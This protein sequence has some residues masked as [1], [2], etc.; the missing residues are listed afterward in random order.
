MNKG[1]K[2]PDHPK[3]SQQYLWP[4]SCTA[5][6]LDRALMEEWT[7]QKQHPSKVSLMNDSLTFHE[8]YYKQ[9]YKSDQ[10]TDLEEW[11]KAVFPNKQGEK[12]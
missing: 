4:N 11:K 6:S 9:K 7:K 8:D 3:S 5:P 10:L 12:L 2:A 1:W